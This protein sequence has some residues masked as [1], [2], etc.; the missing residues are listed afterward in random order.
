[1]DTD[2]TNMKMVG[3]RDREERLQFNSSCIGFSMTPKAM[4]EP[5]LKKRMTQAAA[6]MAHL[7]SARRRILKV[8]FQDN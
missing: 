5:L 1:M 4:R 2:E 3:A 6:R 7:Y 8:S